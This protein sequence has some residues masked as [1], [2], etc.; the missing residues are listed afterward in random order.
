MHNLKASLF[1]RYD[2]PEKY[3]LA[4]ESPLAIAT[5]LQVPIPTLHFL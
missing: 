2:T 4:R 5:R 3:D 1:I